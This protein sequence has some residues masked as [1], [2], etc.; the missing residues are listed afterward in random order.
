M[1]RR[2][3]ATRSKVDLARIGFRICDELGEMLAGNAGSTSITLA[4]RIMPA[5]GT[6]SR[7]KSNGSFS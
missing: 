6:L 1:R 5:T 4:N 2:A 7:M 3:D